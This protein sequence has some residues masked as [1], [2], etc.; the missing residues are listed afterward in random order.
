MMI[1]VMMI[2]IMIIIIMIIIMMIIMMIN[3]KKKARGAH[4]VEDEGVAEG[5]H[6]KWNSW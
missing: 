1:K 5:H 6:K 2:K 3:L 4:L